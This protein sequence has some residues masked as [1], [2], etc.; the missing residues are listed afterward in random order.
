MAVIFD[1][2]SQLQDIE[3]KSRKMKPNSGLVAALLMM[4]SVKSIADIA[5]E[6]YDHRVANKLAESMTE[7]ASDV[8]GRLSDYADVSRQPVLLGADSPKWAESGFDAM[9]ADERM[10]FR[11]L[12]EHYGREMTFTRHGL[13]VF[14]KKSKL[15]QGS[16]TLE[17]VRWV[18]QSQATEKTPVFSA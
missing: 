3:S 12:Y 15:K 2:Y 7:E 8:V 17:P 14:P 6:Q 1:T 9:S 16:D 4:F 10:V 5:V 11:R 18:D 13:V